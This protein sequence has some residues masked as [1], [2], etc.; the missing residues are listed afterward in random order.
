MIN[1]EETERMECAGYKEVNNIVN[2]NGTF[3]TRVRG[4]VMLVIGEGL[5]L[6]APKIQA[7]TERLD[8]PGW[9]FISEFV[10]KQ[11]GSDSKGS[12]EKRRL[13]KK[14]S[15]YMEDVIAGRPVFGA[16]REPGG[17]RLRYGR[18]RATGLAAAG[19]NPVSYT[20]LRAPETVLDIV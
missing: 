20:H 5:C 12:E 4:G 18:S 7:H 15:K 3:R 2:E 10:D 8:V 9:G 19:L 6:K 1:G 16:P 14:E 13:I 11:K 17:F